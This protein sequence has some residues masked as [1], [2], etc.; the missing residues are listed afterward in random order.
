MMAGSDRQINYFADGRGFGEGQPRNPF[1]CQATSTNST[2]AVLA[3]VSNL[4][5]EAPDTRVPG[6]QLRVDSRCHIMPPTG[7]T[8]TIMPKRKAVV[9]PKRMIPFSASIAPMSCQ[10]SVRYRF[11]CP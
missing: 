8:R 9:S 6:H 4:I 1:P 10:C 3:T 5:S 11:A 7:Q 2:P